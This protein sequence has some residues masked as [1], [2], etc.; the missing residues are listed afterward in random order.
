MY[1]FLP[2]FVKSVL[3]FYPILHPP[4]DCCSLITRLG[5]KGQPWCPDVAFSL[6]IIRQ[7]LLPHKM[8]TRGRCCRSWLSASTRSYSSAQLLMAMGACVTRGEVTGFPRTLNSGIA[9]G[10][11]QCCLMAPVD[12]QKGAQLHALAKLT[13]EVATHY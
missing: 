1:P 5:Q 10:G 9:V 3:R 4:H 7:I 8:K 11:H 12:L 13:G 6:R 2:S